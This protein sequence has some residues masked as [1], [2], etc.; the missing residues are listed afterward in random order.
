MKNIQRHTG[1]EAERVASFYVP[2][3]IYTMER[4]RLFFVNWTYD[5]VERIYQLR[6]AI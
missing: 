2:V 1:K 3:Q 5:G 6:W 4:G